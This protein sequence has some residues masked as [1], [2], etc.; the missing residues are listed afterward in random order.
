MIL[1]INLIDYS[2]VLTDI[3][4]HLLLE[5]KFFMEKKT[6]ANLASITFFKK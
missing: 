5:H 2:P 3:N 6:N 1:K 4:N